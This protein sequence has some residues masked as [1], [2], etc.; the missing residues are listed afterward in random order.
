MTVGGGASGS[1]A[2]I[3]MAGFAFSGAS[4]VAVGE[5]VT[6]RN[7]DAVPHTWTA[8]DG[9]FDSGTIGAGATFT[10]TFDEPGEYAY[11]CTIHPTMSGTITVE[12]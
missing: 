8:D 9:S 11:V 5:E 3:T 1:G 4:T 6:V 7:D 10:F 2:L 12:G